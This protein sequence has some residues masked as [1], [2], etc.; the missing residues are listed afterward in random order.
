MRIVTE[1]AQNHAE[2][3]THLIEKGRYQNFQQFITTAIENQI[4]IE[5]ADIHN[6]TTFRN[7]KITVIEKESDE[8][9]N[10]LVDVDIWPSLRNLKNKPKIVQIPKFEDLACSSDKEGRLLNEEHVW[11]WG[12]VNRIFPIKLGLRILFLMLGDGETVDLETF[13]NKA[14]DVA[15][16]F[17]KMIRSHERDANK[18][19]DERISAGL[20]ID[21]ESFRKTLILEMRRNKKFEDM[22][23]YLR[24][25]EFKSKNRYKSHFLASA[26]KNDKLDGAMPYLRL[27][28]LSI[29]TNGK[30]SIGL[31]DDGLNFAK[32]DNPII[33]NKDFTKSL[34]EKEIDFYLQHIL[35]K[36]KGENNAI[37]W[38]LQKLTN[39]IGNREEINKEIEKDFNQ[40]WNFSPPV[41]NTQRAGLMARIFELGLIMKEKQGINVT[42]T[43]APRGEQFLARN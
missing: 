26:R 4:Y 29:G 22:E 34:G 14:G 11:L 37:K 28:N 42:Y 10:L 3:I 30:F 41:I 32:L 17:G 36:A 12:Q 1:I 7:N 39:G 8:K 20:P 31:T 33:D 19:R 16:A 27:V 24:Q 6:Q 38:L 15:L 40:I 13:K 5:D 43:I 18:N 2:K 9:G 21:N 23:P 35:K 25:E